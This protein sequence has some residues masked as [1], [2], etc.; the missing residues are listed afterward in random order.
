MLK[1]IHA[2]ESREATMHKAA[3][4]IRGFREMKL[5]NASDQV[6]EVIEETLTYYRYPQ[7]ALDTDPHSQSLG[8][9]PAGNSTTDTGSGRV[10]R[11]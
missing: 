8:A 6:K 5:Q 2:R 10:S 9:D 3:E 7:D 4:V 1:A 11:R